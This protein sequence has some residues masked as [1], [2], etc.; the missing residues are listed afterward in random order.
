MYWVFTS[1]EP[2]GNLLTGMTLLLVGQTCLAID[3][4]R[5]SRLHSWTGWPPVAAVTQAP[6]PVG[7]SV[8][9]YSCGAWPT[10]ADVFSQW[11][12]RSR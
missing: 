2:G 9:R 11:S 7:P 10:S 3:G 1:A 5:D 8:F 6:L 4:V 12:I